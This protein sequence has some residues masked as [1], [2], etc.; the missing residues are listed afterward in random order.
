[1]DPKNKEIVLA[2]FLPIIQPEARELIR[3]KCGDVEKYVLFAFE[4]STALGRRFGYF[5]TVFLTLL[6]GGL[7]A[8]NVINEKDVEIPLW[9]KIVI[10]LVFALVG[11]LIGLMSLRMYN[12]SLYAQKNFDEQSVANFIDL[13]VVDKLSVKYL[14][15]ISEDKWQ[16]IRL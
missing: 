9:L 5:F 11:L 15:K 6:L 1:M 2:R 13:A 12:R 16:E 8:L 7:M 14:N 4:K 10:P 3:I